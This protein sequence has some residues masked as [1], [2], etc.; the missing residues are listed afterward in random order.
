MRLAPVAVTLNEA[1]SPVHTLLLEGCDVIDI[2]PV[3]TVRVAA[4]DGMVVVGQ[5]P[6]T[7]QRYWLLFIP[8]VTEASVSVV[9]VSAGTVLFQVTPPSV[10]T[11]QL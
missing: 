7:W 9:D 1:S 3:V 10:L 4:L 2:E 8:D 6:V 11:C 5:P